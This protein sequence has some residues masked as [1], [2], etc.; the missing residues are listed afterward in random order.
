MFTTYEVREIL[1]NAIRACP[2]ITR[3][4]FPHLY[5]STQSSKG[6]VMFS[7][8]TKHVFR[9][10]LLFISR[11]YYANEIAKKL[12][13][14]HDKVFSFEN[15]LVLK[16]I[17]ECLEL[18]LEELGQ[19]TKKVSSQ[20][21]TQLLQRVTADLSFCTRHLAQVKKR[22]ENACE[23][24]PVL[25]KKVKSLERKIM[26]K[27]SKKAAAAPI[28]PA[29]AR[30]SRAQEVELPSVVMAEM[31]AK[32]VDERDRERKRKREG[33]ERKEEEK[34]KKKTKK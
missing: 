19:Q 29:A 9:R 18:C 14:G 26:A 20:T 4:D 5:K 30:P 22:L 24:V 23:I 10:M 31:I 8:I 16:E 11:V 17:F 34:T 32:V 1:Y 12:I 27:S 6:Y 33:E 7:K 28:S 2:D 15:Y 3:A 13:E 25:S 21:A